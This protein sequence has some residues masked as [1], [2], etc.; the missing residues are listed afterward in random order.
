MNTRSTC[1]AAAILAAAAPQAMAQQNI[2]K[3]VNVAP[4]VTVE[5]SNVQGSLE[6]TAWDRNEVEL[7]AELESDKDELEFEATERHVHIE[8]DRPDGKY[9]RNSDEQDAILTLRVPKGARLVAEKVSAGI[10]VIGLTKVA[11]VSSPPSAESRTW[12]P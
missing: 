1:L 6:I 11:S 7:V 4:D 8:V 3:R 10:T 5:V 9:G 12:S 2:T